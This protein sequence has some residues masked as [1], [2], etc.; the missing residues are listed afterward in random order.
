MALSKIQDGLLDNNSVSDA[1]IKASTITDG[2][3]NL[4]ESLHF[5]KLTTLNQTTN[6]AT[7]FTFHSVFNQ[8]YEY[9]RV[10]GY[11]GGTVSTG[12]ANL[13]VRFV[14]GTGTVISTS[15]YHSSNWGFLSDGNANIG[16]GTGADRGYILAHTS[17]GTSVYVD[18]IVVPNNRWLYGQLYAHD[19]NTH[20]GNTTFGVRFNAA[21]SDWSGL[22]ILNSGGD[23]LTT[24]DAT[25]YGAHVDGSM[26]G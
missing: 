2:R 25:V 22:Y 12:N 15:S 17:T 7:T 5:K 18:M 26:G 23:N 8:G 24:V 13:A 1:N 11:L 3:L 10:V 20:I 4:T 6:T 14:T 19:Q 21:I 16:Y 9:Y